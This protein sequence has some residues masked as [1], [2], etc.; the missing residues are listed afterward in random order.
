M[1]IWVKTGKRR[2]WWERERLDVFPCFGVVNEFNISLPLAPKDVDDQFE[3]VKTLCA[4]E[5][6]FPAEKLRKDASNRPHINGGSIVVT[7]EE[8]F[9]GPV[10]ASDHILSHEL[11][12]A[13]ASSS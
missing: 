6:R 11:A 5:Y 7:A 10:P 1:G 8:E 4:R 13:S 9:W 12:L 3:L 2:P